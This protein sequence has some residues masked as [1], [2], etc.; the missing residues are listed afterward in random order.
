MDQVIVKKSKKSYYFTKILDQLTRGLLKKIP[1]G[2]KIRSTTGVFISP[3][4]LFT[5]FTNFYYTFLNFTCT[6]ASQSQSP[7]YLILKKIV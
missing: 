2:L 1:I 7:N 6:H 4:L 3:D 5:R